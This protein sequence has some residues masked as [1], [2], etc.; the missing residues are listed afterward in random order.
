MKAIPFAVGLAAGIVATGVAVS[1]LYPDVSRR[2]MRDS[3]RAVRS[4]RR[5]INGMFN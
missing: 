4:G 5:V 3:R 2:V 1:A